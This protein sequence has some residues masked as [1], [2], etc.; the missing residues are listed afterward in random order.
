[1]RKAIKRFEEGH[2]EKALEFESIEI[3]VESQMAI[4]YALG[5]CA[6]AADAEDVFNHIAGKGAVFVPEPREGALPPQS[7][8][9][10]EAPIDDA[11]LKAWDKA[12]PDFAGLL[13]AEVINR[14]HY[15]PEE[16]Q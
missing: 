13:D 4:R 16:E 6:T 1:M 2:P 9:E 10:D 11:D 5:L 3:P 14:E 12:L 15:D 7:E 8:P